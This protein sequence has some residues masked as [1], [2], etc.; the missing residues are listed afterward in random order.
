M[1]KTA[2]LE[3]LE[4]TIGRYVLNLDAESLNVAVW[5]GKIELQSL[6]LDVAA[7]NS[8]LSRRAHEAPNLASPFRVCE[9]RF[10]KVQL[11][12]PWARLSSRPVVFRASG[13]WVYMEP[14]DFLK[15]DINVENRWGTKVH[16]KK[17][18]K[19]GKDGVV[20]ERI[21]SIS[22]AEANRQRLSAVRM[23]WEEDDD[24]SNN[25]EEDDES[26]ISSSSSSFTSRLVRRIIENLQVEVEDV[27]IAVRGCGCAAG[28]VLGSLSLVTTDAKGHRSFVD[29]KTNAK[30]PA[31]SFLYKELLISGFGIY[32]QNDTVTQDSMQRR[33]IKMSDKAEYVLEPLDFQAKLRQSDLDHCVDFPKYLV[34]SKLSS[35]SVQLSRNQLELGQRLALAVSPNTE[36]RPLFPEYRPLDPVAGNAKQWW[37][38]AIRCIGRLN[39]HRL[40]IEFFVAFRK[41]KVYI[42]L[43]KRNAHAD[44]APWLEKL[45]VSDRAELTAIETDRSIS[46][47][48]LMHW[49]T[50]ADAQVGKEREKRAIAA[51]N[52]R[53]ENQGY[54]AVQA[55]TS[56]SSSI[57]SS[58]AS[59]L[60][61]STPK[62][63]S[64]R[65]E[66]SDT[67]YECLD[68]DN[69]DAPIT[70]TPD[71]MK[72]LEELAMKRVDRGALTKDSMFCDINFAMGSF[73][74]NLLRA[75]NQPLTS[76]E[77][78]MV[79]ASFKAKADGS[80]TSGLSLL[81]LEV[82]DSVTTN[83]FYP[84]I[85]RSL[86]KANSTKSHAFQFQ[87]KKSKEGDQ[88][89]VLK[90][91]ACEIVASPMLLFAIKE[92]FKLPEAA[93]R[94]NSSVTSTGGRSNPIL[95]ESVSG[96]EDLFFDAKEGMS[97]MIL[98][99]LASTAKSHFNYETPSKNI[100]N[101]SAIKD[102][103]VSDK[104][105]SA[106]M[107]A[108]NGK[109]QR[110][111]KWNITADISAPILILPENC[112]DPNATVLICNFGRF[113]FTYGTEA[114][115]PAVVEWFNSRQ[116][117]H[118]MD[119]EID[120][121]K[122]EMNDLSFTIS[123]VRESAKKRLDEMNVN[124]VSTS[125]IEPISFTLDIGLE[126][127]I[128]AGDCT[129]RTC[130]VGVLPGIALSLAPS[131]I[132]K[133]LGVSAIWTSNLS[134][135]R[136]EVPDGA[137][138][139]STAL[140]GVD[141]EEEEGEIG[142]PDLEIMSSGSG[143]SI[144]DGEEELPVATSGNESLLSR[145]DRLESLLLSKQ[146]SNRSNAVE[147]VHVSLSL[148]KL[149]LNMY[150]DEGDGIEAHLVSVSVSS[151]LIT[152]GTS[153]SKL[154][155]GWFWILDRLK[156]EHQLPR[157]QRLV[158]HSNLPRPAYEYAQND[159]YTS[160]MNDL[161]EQGVF[162]PGYRSADLADI[163]IIKL[164]INKARSY[165]EQNK[166]F[167]PGYMQSISNVHKTTVINAK[168]TSLF[169]NWNPHAIKTL[170]AAKSDVLDF[171]AKAYSTYERMSML[172]KQHDQRPS[173]G[174]KQQIVS[175]TEI[176]NLGAHSVFILA[177]MESFEISLNSAK[178]DLPLFTL[179]MSKSTINHHSL[180]DDDI[181]SEMTITVGDF[182]MEASP[183]GRI[184]KS[185]RTIL[186]LA[187][188]ASTSLLSIKYGKGTHAVKSCNVG[189]AD[190]VSCEACAEI[191]L[192][193]MRFVHI[194]SQVFTLIEYVSEG[195]FGTIAASVALSAAA[196]AKQVAKSSQNGERLFYVVASGFNLVV[197]QAAYSEEY[198]SFNAGNFKAHYRVFEDDIGS[199]AH[200]SL[201]DVSMN[202]N[203]NMQ[204]VHTPVNMSVT[205][206][207]KPPLLQ[208]LTEDERATRVEMSISRIRLLIARCHYAQ[209]MHTID[210]NIGEAD[211][212]LRA[213]NKAHQ[214]DNAAVNAILKTLS[215][216][217]VEAVDVIKRMYINFNI[218]ELAVEFCGLT[219]DDPIMSLAAVKAHILMKLIPDEKQTRAYVTLHDLVCDDRRIGSAD[220]TF[221]RIIGRAN[222]NKISTSSIKM[223]DQ[224][225]ESEVFLLNYTKYS[226]DESRDIEVKIGSS[227][228]VVLPDVI[229]DMLNFIQV[230]PYPYQRSISR[231]VRSTSSGVVSPN[232]SATTMQVVV[233]DYDPDEV[234][235]SYEMGSKSGLPA[236]KKTNYKIESSNMRLVLVDLGNIDSSGPFESSK[237][238]SALTETIV[239]QGK[240]QAKFD[241]V[242]DRASNVTVEKDYRVDAERVEIYTAQ[243]SS[244]LHPVQILEPAKFAIFYYQKVGSGSGS[245][246]SHLTDVKF[247]TL[248][249]IDLTVSMQNAALASTLAS[250]ISDSF[251]CD[252]DGR[253]EDDEFHSLSATDAN[254]IARLDSALMKDDDEST[255]CPSEHMSNVSVHT[256]KQLQSTRRIIK[257]KLTS[258]E[259]TLTVTNDFQG[260]DE[261]LFKICSMNTVF[262]G[263]ISYPGVSLRENPCFGCNINTR[264]AL[265]CVQRIEYTNISQTHTLSSFLL[266]FAVS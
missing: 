8:E 37:R 176:D 15:E 236:L 132:T 245:S 62:R 222:V 82:M 213:E 196:A 26:N 237:K 23:A 142:D 56:R 75:P 217:G 81:S 265:E 154:T 100:H 177:Q 240:M 63:E 127:T 141:E 152:D 157:Q 55:K 181:N 131:H 31:S 145:K 4:S 68:D 45:K 34:H 119:S 83:T 89:V 171:K 253:D 261:A 184:L 61:G 205:V 250:S 14:H 150:T 197:P 112:I 187:P 40:W 32:L 258:P 66:S 168:F 263:E 25:T 91:V 194:H 199:E 51:A 195:V 80:F 125:V 138:E 124:D 24:G 85:C 106:I 210:Y 74:V 57:K 104:L 238:A 20:E 28:L 19:D 259:A 190:K 5:S 162:K 159:Q 172:H 13:L 59:S 52:K 30:N 158:C 113:N 46:I 21:T 149:S 98:S 221:K 64:S 47:T 230:A 90:M 115:S 114:L 244:L 109:N 160:I 130:V 232:G 70:L 65:R 155:M 7:V 206:K 17:K 48:G 233:N 27:H 73:Q 266:S 38:Y 151:S 255:Q 185:Y 58:L 191:V 126:H 137:G 16:S 225:S 86:Q 231:T 211:T 143:I 173:I 110:K 72:E 88:E 135:L 147:F 146:D 169:V 212:F 207:M 96:D 161:T 103:K 94:N 234:E 219:T 262:G 201:K 3:V 49:R 11:D 216:A 200:V 214:V 186:G 120:H 133:I 53:N 117:A 50:I 6:Q 42:E 87:L 264:R 226:E 167:S 116:R 12:V 97:T 174:D 165:H 257:L 43:Y 102:G 192:S 218:Q 54:L 84:T 178:D 203:Q 39:R 77:M 248:S 153:N 92:F 198:F 18:R 156:S 140:S 202:C 36:I 128:S 163:S 229:S 251:S 179:T 44:S 249:P 78:G 204:M 9:G 209:M 182:R 69:N 29:R 35:L 224:G 129:A 223:K 183:F 118:R 2:I 148:L 215:H 256:G 252:K 247:V 101:S 93:Q 79:S 107:D 239:L 121:L 164:P 180:E 166:D 227:Q 76:L 189:G 10:E 108:W 193:P 22:R 246:A 67:F 235:T 111:Q 123:T 175:E 99:P 134:K 242:N 105:S 170:F 241:M 228:V 139:R 208:G 95:F 1:A 122:L 41:R 260:L 71:E 254:R 220:R 33:M 136:G 188:S 144:L 243:G 60:F